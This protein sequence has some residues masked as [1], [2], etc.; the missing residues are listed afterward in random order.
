MEGCIEL[1]GPDATYFMKDMVII[2]KRVVS[3]CGTTETWYNK[4]G[5]LHRDGFPAVIHYNK[6]GQRFSEGWYKDDKLH[7]DDLPALVRY[8][9][10]GGKSEEAWYKD[11]VAYRGGDLPHVVYYRE[12]GQ[13]S[14]E[15]WWQ[16][17]S[18]HRDGLP[19]II[20]YYG[21]GQICGEYW[22]KN[23]NLQPSDKMRDAANGQAPMSIEDRLA[24]LE[25]AVA[26]LAKKQ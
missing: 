19:A 2:A 7:R 25:A 1:T 18:L 20:T 23:G 17:K 10:S 3:A 13:K 15:E 11:G 24:K 26:L 12:N 8:Y 16:G 6:N 22:F 21:H 9:K 5:E 4:A 14:Q